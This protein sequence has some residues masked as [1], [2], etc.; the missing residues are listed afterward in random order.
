MPGAVP[1][2]M[3]PVAPLQPSAMFYDGKG[4]PS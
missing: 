2:G 1:Y 4:K 3:V